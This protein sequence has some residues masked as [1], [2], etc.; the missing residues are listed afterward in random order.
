MSL[1]TLVH[2]ASRRA[3][4]SSVVTREMRA[5]GARLARSVG[6]AIEEAGKFVLT[7]AILAAVMAALA[8]LDIMIWLPRVH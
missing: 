8:A 6:P 1:A 4:P 5:V 2:G 7:L 3:A